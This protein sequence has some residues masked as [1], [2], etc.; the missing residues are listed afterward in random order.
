MTRS[1]TLFTMCA[2][3]FCASLTAQKKKVLQLP[4]FD[5][6]PLYWGFYLGLN[7]INYKLSYQ[8]SIYD[9]KV[10]FENKIGFNVGLIGGVKLRENIDLHIEP[11]LYSNRTKIIYE[12][13]DA[14]LKKG[15]EEVD[16]GN[17]RE[18]SSTFLHV[19]ILVKISTNRLNNIRPYMIGGVSYDHNFSSNED[20][21]N[22]NTD[23]INGFRMTTNNFMYEIGFGM[24][25]Y[26]PYFK[27]SPSIRGLFAINSELVRDDG[28]SPWTDPIDFMGTRGIFLKLSFE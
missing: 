7:T 15:G 21:A 4:D 16:N 27:F 24:D 3:V 14:V 5:E 20:N 1:I 19:P 6:R 22:D 25:F 23:D 10:N 9:S 11:G 18:V 26:F 17:I 8:E 12:G 28:P 13:D 2:L